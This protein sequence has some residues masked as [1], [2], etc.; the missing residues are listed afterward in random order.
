MIGRLTLLRG[1]QIHTLGLLVQGCGQFAVN[2]EL[3]HDPRR[4]IFAVFCQQLGALQR[5]FCLALTLAVKLISQGLQIGIELLALFLR[6]FGT[7]SRQFLTVIGRQLGQ[8]QLIDQGFQ[9]GR[10]GLQAE[11]LRIIT[12]LGADT[13]LDFVQLAASIGLL[14]GQ[15]AER[16]CDFTRPLLLLLRLT[17]FLQQ[18]AADLQDFLIQGVRRHARRNVTRLIA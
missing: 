11:I 2:L 17:A 18:L 5:A 14:L 8:L 15:L 7:H 4:E 16:I 3:R 6:Q 12:G 1:H 9:F 10:F 13:T